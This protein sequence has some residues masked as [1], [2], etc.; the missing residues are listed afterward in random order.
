MT[1]PE[2]L[3]AARLLELPG[4]QHAFDLFYSP[5]TLAVIRG[6]HRYAEILR[7]NNQRDRA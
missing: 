3:L 1:M 6:I 2:W 5:R 7:L 4:A